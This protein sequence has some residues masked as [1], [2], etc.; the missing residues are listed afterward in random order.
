MLHSVAFTLHAYCI[1]Q[2]AYLI[3]VASAIPCGASLIS[4]SSSPEI[5]SED[6]SRLGDGIVPPMVV[7]T[8]RQGLLDVAYCDHASLAP[9]TSNASIRLPPDSVENHL[10]SAKRLFLLM[11]VLAYFD[12]VLLDRRTSSICIPRRM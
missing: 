11:L 6:Q 7:W 8:P 3:V 5:S 1:P 2:P 10:R 12:M 4:S 9:L